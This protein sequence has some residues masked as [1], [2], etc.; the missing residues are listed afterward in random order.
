[1]P[2][3][4]YYCAACNKTSSFLLLRATEKIEPYCRHCK[5]TK[6]KRVLSRVAVLRSEEKR[7]ESLLD[8]ARLG[9]FDENDPGSVE[10]LMRKMGSE[11]GDDLGEGFEEDMEEALASEEVSPEED[12]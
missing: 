5:S 1:M 2:I 8:P 11:L 3:Y 7:M 12:L 9:D 10:K 6:V 4:E